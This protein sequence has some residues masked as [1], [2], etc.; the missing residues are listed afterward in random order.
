MT[1]K[2]EAMMRQSFDPALVV[3]GGAMRGIFSTGVLDGFLA[4]GFNPFHLYLGVS[5]GATS[6]AAYLAEMPGRNRRIYTELSI[7][8]EF[9]NPL[10]FIRGGHLMDLDW[11]WQITISQMRLDLPMIYAKRKPF[12]VGLTDARTGKAVYK[13]SAADDLEH[14]LRASSALPLFYRDFPEVDGAPMTD[15]G[16]SDPIPVGEAIRRGARRIMVIRSRSGNYHKSR[17]PWNYC[18]GWMLRDRPLLRATI[19]GQARI[20]NEAVSLIFSP[21]SGVSIMQVCPP[22]NFRPGRFTRDPEVLQEGYEQ[23][24]AAAADAMSRWESV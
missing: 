7:R 19:I 13:E 14:L 8:P 18:M 16:V 15:G 22:A 21:P 1:E 2:T 5:A 23:G 3:E 4:R 24:F 11:H 10:R 20:Y 6:L 9:I 12:I 17:D